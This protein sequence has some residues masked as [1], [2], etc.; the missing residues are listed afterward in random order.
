MKKITLHIVFINAPGF[1]PG[2]YLYKLK[3]GDTERV[4]RIIVN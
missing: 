1:I 2:M 3:I 4:E